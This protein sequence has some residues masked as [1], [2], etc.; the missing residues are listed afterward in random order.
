MAGRAAQSV[1]RAREHGGCAT[2]GKLTIALR[3]GRS[4]HRISASATPIAS[5]GQRVNKAC[6]ADF[7]GTRARTRFYFRI[8]TGGDREP[9]SD[10]GSPAARHLRPADQFGGIGLEASQALFGQIA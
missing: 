4:R 7:G 1:S 6:S 9:L 5:F 3:P 8:Q 2:T 10:F